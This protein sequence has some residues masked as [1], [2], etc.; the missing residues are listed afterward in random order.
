VR[1][2][3]TIEGLAERLDRLERRLWLLGLLVIGASNGVDAVKL[4]FF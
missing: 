4:A 2:E 1:L 3:V